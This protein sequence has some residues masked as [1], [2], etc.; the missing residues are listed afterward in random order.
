MTATDSAPWAKG[1]FTY[2]RTD[3]PVW[4]VPAR[5]TTTPPRSPR[6]VSPPKKTV[7][8]CVGKDLTVSKT[9]A[10]TFDRDYLWNIKKAVDKTQVKIANGQTA[11]FNYDVMSGRP[12]SRKPAGPWPGRSPSPTPTTGKTSP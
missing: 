10:G 11:T 12:A 7:T 3:V 2:N 1:T 8:L 6:P 9:A 5:T 4:P